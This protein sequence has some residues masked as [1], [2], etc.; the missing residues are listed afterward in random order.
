MLLDVKVLGS[1]KL[2][3]EPVIQVRDLSKC[4]QIRSTAPKPYHSLREDL[5]D[6]FKGLLRGGMGTVSV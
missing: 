5:V 3:T 1:I 2:M 6:G 4:Y